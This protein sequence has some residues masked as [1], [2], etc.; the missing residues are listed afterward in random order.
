VPRGLDLPS[1]TWVKVRSGGFEAYALWDRTSPI[2]LRVFSRETKPDAVWLRERLRDALAL[3]GALRESGSSAFRLLYGEGDGVPGVTIDIY[4][5]YAVV[6]TYADSLDRL[7]PDVV[8]AL[9]NELALDGVV[10]RRRGER[11]DSRLVLL[12]GQEPP[13]R[14]FVSERGVRFVV[15]LRSG[16]KTGLFLDHRENREFVRGLA[17][18]KSVLNLFAYTGAF[19]VYAALGGA[20]RV[21]SVDVSAGALGLAR[22]NFELNE[23]PRAMHQTIAA[24]VFEYLEPSREQPE[25]FDLVIS[26]PPSFATSRDQQF[27]ALRAYVRLNALALSRVRYGGWFATASCTAQASPEAFRHAV[28]EAASRAGVRLQIVHD[29]GQPLDHPI[30]AGHPEGRYLKFIVARVQ[31]LV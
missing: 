28:A 26:D 27:R 31:A 29:A 19:S 14:L 10:Q 23:L 17:R 1:G 3:R 5:S 4:D 8:E 20:E 13:D 11:E 24:D 15:E 25:L 18:G 21:V 6:V 9:G 30:M 16:Q 12:S 2:A 22:E 7:L